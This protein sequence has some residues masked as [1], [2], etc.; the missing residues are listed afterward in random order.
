MGDFPIKGCVVDT[1][2]LGHS[3]PLSQSIVP[4]VTMVLK[5][6]TLHFEQIIVLAQ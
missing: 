4:D 2:H 5:A 1:P 6:T 3:A